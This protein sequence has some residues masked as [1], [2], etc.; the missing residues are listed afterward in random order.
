MNKNNKTT[1][2]IIFS[3]IEREFKAT[4]KLPK[5]QAEIIKIFTTKSADELQKKGILLWSSYKSEKDEPDQYIKQGEF[6]YL[7][8]KE[9]YPN[10][11]EGMAITNILGD[12][13]KFIPGETD[14]DSRFGCLCFGLVRKETH[15]TKSE[16]E[17]IMKL[18]GAK[19][20]HPTF[21]YNEWISMVS[22]HTIITAEGYKMDC[23]EFWS[24]RTAKEFQNDWFLVFPNE[25]K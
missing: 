14:D 3:P 16:A 17:N 11:P 2:Q 15:L 24:Y 12:E 10:I 25:K 6:H 13:L 8:P 1:I 7:F 5:D 21:S 19:V 4:I 18:L 9:W 22:P 20:S 23:E